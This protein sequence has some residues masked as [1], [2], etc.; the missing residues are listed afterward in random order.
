MAV[1]EWAGNPKDGSTGS[2]GNSYDDGA[3]YQ[4]SIQEG[5]NTFSAGEDPLVGENLLIGAYM[6]S[7]RFE[8]PDNEGHMITAY[9]QRL[10]QVW[11]QFDA[12]D[13][14]WT[15]A[16]EDIVSLSL[17]MV[18]SS[19]AYTSST[20]AKQD[21]MYAWIRDATMPPGNDWAN[22]YQLSLAG[23]PDITWEKLMS[24][25]S[26]SGQVFNF[27]EAGSERFMTNFFARLAAG[28]KDMGL[29]QVMQ[30]ELDDYPNSAKT[31]S[32]YF[33]ASSG[34]THESFKPKLR[35]STAR[36]HNLNHCIGASCQLTDG[37]AIM[38]N[39]NGT[40]NRYEMRY[41]KLAETS[42]TLIATGSIGDAYTLFGALAG[43]QTVSVCRDDSNNLY[44]AGAS[45]TTVYGDICYWVAAAFK[46]NGNYSW[47]AKAAGT[48]AEGNNNSF[49]GT[50]DQD[51]KVNN[52]Q[53]NWIP[54]TSGPTGGTVAILNSRRAGHW[55]WRQQNITTLN[56]NYLLA[57]AGSVKNEQSQSHDPAI[58]P[59][60]VWRPF[61]QSGSGMDMLPVGTGNKLAIGT[62]YP[63]RSISSEPKHA[64]VTSTVAVGGLASKPVLAAL[65]GSSL[66]SVVNDPDGKTRTPWM[67][68]NTRY[69]VMNAGFMEIRNVVDDALF[70]ALD[71][72]TFN[73][74]NFPS[75]EQLQSSSAWDVIWDVSRACF[76]IYYIDSQNP[77]LLRKVSYDP[78]S[79]TLDPSLQFTPS[80]LGPSGS[81]IVAI[82]APRGKV[83]N[84]CVLIDV[85]MIDGSLAPTAV[86]TLRDIS[87][88]HVP[89]GPGISDVASFN[90]TA[91]KDIPWFFT[92]ADP[93]DI[94]TKQD[95]EIRRV[96]N[97]S[98]VHNPTNQ[99]AVLVSGTTYKYT[100][101][102][103][104]LSNDT[105]YQIRIRAY[106]AV[107]GQG[108]WS[109]Y[110]S[111]TTSSTGGTVT[112]TQPAE[113]NLPMNV[114]SVVLVWTY[115]NTNPAITQTG[116]QVKTYNNDTNVLE[117]DTGIVASTATTYTKT[118]LSSGVHHRIEVSVRGSDNN[119][120]GGGIRIVYPDYNNPS[121]PTILAV[122]TQGTIDIRI[123][124]PPPTGENP[125]TVSNQISRKL[126][127]ALD[128]T[129]QV[130]GTAPVNGTFSDQSVASG[131]EYTYRVRGVSGSGA[132]G[133]WS[134]EATAT[135]QLTGMWISI[136]NEPAY[137]TIQFPL[138]GVGRQESADIA[139]TTQQ[140]VGR[141]YPITDFGTSKVQALAIQTQIL[142]PGENDTIE[143]G[144]PTANS[145]QVAAARR[146]GSDPIVILYRDQRGRKMYATVSGFSMVDIE[147][148]SYDV[149]MTLNRV[150]YDESIL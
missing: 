25:R 138:G 10:Y 147:Q 89:N 115:T 47:T 54:N 66:R 119:V 126:A 128:A 109:D 90:A 112:I 43:N 120:S 40:L 136:P 21:G 83:D 141:E 106:D 8:D 118:G 13:T 4:F 97:G 35:V 55:A 6:T 37:T 127:G 96:S 68:S 94:A 33:I 60:A 82:R 30:A 93:N 16:Q 104:T 85:A 88:N 18:R 58:Q 23:N 19:Y 20:F 101:P 11:Q 145:Q 143:A 22:L 38:F 87:M 91:A 52:V 130:I 92:D 111:F 26:P 48:G 15:P 12:V 45:G 51:G 102:G 27:Y 70:R 2:G 75:F 74:T 79:N 36:K 49:G 105:Q 59:D 140:F 80:N 7:Q 84:R 39:W 86:I 14:I 132:T 62:Y 71:F 108:V 110:V 107:G 125:V 1:V 31:Y 67:N 133:G 69:A 42:S 146:L 95:I 72:T 134:T 99:T 129:Y 9:I 73:I 144:Q 53:I 122:P 29:L 64:T 123:T 81:R 32:A 57:V 24:D 121:I 44:V 137:G 131:Q 142:G 28:K 100:I 34:S 50:N 113:D 139:K 78:E 46:Y 3:D 124:N 61:N 135:A 117:S 17:C 5:L 116:Y 114:S 150:D 148:G 65:G 56:A 76:W 63:S 149:T 41:Q 98:V 103:G 77:R